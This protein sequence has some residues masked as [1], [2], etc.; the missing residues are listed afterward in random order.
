[1]DH[2]LRARPATT[3]AL[4]V[5]LR[6]SLPSSHPT[7]GIPTICAQCSRRQQQPVFAYP[8]PFSTSAAQLSGHNKWSKIKHDKGRADAKKSAQR[9]LLTRDIQLATRLYGPDPKMNGQLVNAIATAR[10]AGVPKANIDAAIARGQGRSSTGASLETV[11]LETMTA[12][13]SSGD[14]SVSLVIEILTDNRNRALHDVRGIIRKHNGI[15]TPTTFLFEKAGRTVLKLGGGGDEASKDGVKIVDAAILPAA[16]ESDFDNVMMQAIEAGA[17]DVEDIGD[18]MFVV[19]TPPTLTHKAAQ[20]LN[21]GDLKAQI[22]ESAIV[23]TPSQDRVQLP[24]AE[25]AQAFADFLDALR[26]YNDVQ[27]VYANVEQGDITEDVWDSI[28]ENLD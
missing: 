4:R 12:S 14:G 11:V 28:E 20:A 21:L 24:D 15:L 2:L 22:V 19:W 3:S 1:M 9:G 13:T 8:K 26:D 5:L 27:G 16:G 23:W 18:G 6:R 17:D 25:S 10:K 7:S